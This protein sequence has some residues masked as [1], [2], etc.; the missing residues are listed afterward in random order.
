MSSNIDKINSAKDF[1]NISHQSHQL[2]KEGKFEQ[3]KK[4]VDELIKFIEL[5][6]KDDG[7]LLSVATDVVPSNS[8]CGHIY[9][10]AGEVYGEL[11]DEDKA[12]ELYKKARYYQAHLKNRFENVSNLTVYLFR[13]FAGEGETD[14]NLDNMCHNQ[15][16]LSDP[17]EM[18]DPMDSLYFIWL[19]SPN[20]TKTSFHKKHLS[21][22]KKSFE[23]FRIRSFCVD[24]IEREEYAVRNTLMWSHYA[25]NHTGYCVEYS[26][27]RSDFKKDTDDTITY[28][29]PIIYRKSDVNLSESSS[30]NSELAFHT[31]SDCWAY[32]NEVRLISYKTDGKSE[33]HVNYPLSDKSKIKA[34]Y[35]GMKSNKEDIKSLMSELVKVHEDIKFYQMKIDYTNVYRLT[36]EQ[37]QL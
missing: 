20:L 34:I 23:N 3:A 22:L 15:V 21:A 28:L 30:I 10:H 31:K 26:L 13:S 36:F 18:N 37:I 14:Y 5:L 24:N 27:D 32:E 33:S 1:D 17:R 11:G 12:L 29:Q 4:L 35:F 16:S 2:Y 25:A 19:E 8:L 9:S 6:Q 7:L